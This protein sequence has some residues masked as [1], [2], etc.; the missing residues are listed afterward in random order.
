[1]NI[2]R[3]R[4]AAIQE[5]QFPTFEVTRQYL[6]V[7]QVVCQDGVPLIGD[8]VIADPASA[9]VWFPIVGESYYLV[10]YVDFETSPEVRWV[11]TSAG[12][13][14]SLIVVSETSTLEE[15]ITTLQGI[16]PTSTWMK[17]GVRRQTSHGNV[18]WENS[19]FEIEP[20]PKTSGEVEDKIQAIVDILEPHTH[21]L[22]ELATKADHIELSI[23]YFGYTA[24]MWGI[25]LEPE[26]V[27]QLAEL[28]V[29]IDID[30]Y[31]SGPDLSDASE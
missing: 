10:V 16:E 22:A 9:A 2:D 21:Q 27:R 7:N 29:A 31:A 18:I 23:A 11:E 13:K 28:G 26:V 3:I 14:V 6:R 25:H 24:Q 8:I 12:N 15:L 30:L 1:M 4:E 20:F 17:G 19:G 5:V